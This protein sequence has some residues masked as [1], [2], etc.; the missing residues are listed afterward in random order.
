[1]Q[2]GSRNFLDNNDLEKIGTFLRSDGVGRDLK[3]VASACWVP[4][5]MSVNF[6]TGMYWIFLPRKANTCLHIPTVCRGLF[7][8]AYYRNKSN[9]KI[10]PGKWKI[11]TMW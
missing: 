1:M 11:E 5:L 6:D 9:V 8:V 7:D 2:A 4:K 3:W 10:L